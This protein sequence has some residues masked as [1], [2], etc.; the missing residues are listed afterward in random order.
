[1]GIEK[2]VKEIIITRNDIITPI[3]ILDITQN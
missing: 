3:T 1:M 2:T